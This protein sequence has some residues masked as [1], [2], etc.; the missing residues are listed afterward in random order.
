MKLST[1][2]TRASTIITIAVL[3]VGAV[4][5]FFALNYIAGKQLDNDL[6]EEIGEV[7]SYVNLNGHLPKQADFDED[8]TSFLK[9]SRDNI[10]TRF[11]DT[12]YTDPHEKK[13]EPGRAVTGLISLKGER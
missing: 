8:Q 4:I 3:L 13:N 10:A 2:Y 5:Y 7:I 1:H 11:F 9:T 6:T 12:V